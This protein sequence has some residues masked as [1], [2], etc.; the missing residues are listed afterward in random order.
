V[1]GQLHAPAAL[2]SGEGL[3]EPGGLQNR[4][5]CYGEEKNLALPRTER[6]LC[7]LLVVL[8]PTELSRFFDSE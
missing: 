3:P 8:I 1:S 6:R 2:P 4:S 5:R 7:S